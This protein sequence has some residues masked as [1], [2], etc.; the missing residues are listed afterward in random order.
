M[1]K[2]NDNKNKKSKQNNNCNDFGKALRSSGLLL[3][4]TDD[5][6][7]GFNNL[8]GQINGELPERFKNMDFLFENKQKKETIIVTMDLSVKGE[9]S[10]LSYAARDGQEKLP[11]PIL[12]KMKELKTKARE[13]KSSSGNK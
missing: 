12:E 2:Q 4:E 9:E 13:K 1:D 10:S 8:Y 11:E 5:E 6:V 7:Q 3:P